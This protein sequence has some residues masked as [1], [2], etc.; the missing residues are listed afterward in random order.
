L[1]LT[2]QTASVSREDAL[3]GRQ[4]ILVDAAGCPLG[5]LAARVASMLRGKD[6]PDFTPNQDCGDFVV[7]V[8]AQKV[9]LTGAKLEQKA[10][11][12]HSGYPGGIRKTTAGRILQSKPERLIEMAVRGML[13]KNRLGRQLFTK[14]KVYRGS[15]HPHA[16]Q[17]PAQVTVKRQG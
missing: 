4:W 13:P 11:Y 5:R 7:V 6:R 17:A 14:L 16:A 15:E 2:E 8:N 12:R 9:E 1:K 3:R 10:Y